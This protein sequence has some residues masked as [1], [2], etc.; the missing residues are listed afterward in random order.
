MNKIIVSFRQI[1]VIPIKNTQKAYD[2]IKIHK[3]QRVTINKTDS[4]TH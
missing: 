1:N 3:Q 2:I 4:Q